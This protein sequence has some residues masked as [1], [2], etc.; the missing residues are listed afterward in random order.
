MIT[1]KIRSQT[2]PI[3]VKYIEII[4]LHIVQIFQYI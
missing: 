1:L 4:P 2:K 3:F